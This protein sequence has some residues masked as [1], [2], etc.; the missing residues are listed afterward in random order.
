[1]SLLSSRSASS[2][3]VLSLAGVVACT[4]SKSGTTTSSASTTTTSTGGGWAYGGYGGYG[5]DGGY[6]DTGGYGGDGGEGGYGGGCFEDGDI[7]ASDLDCCGDDSYCI[8]GVCG[9]CGSDSQI[10][11]AA[12]GVPELCWPLTTD[13]STITDC[14]GAYKSC[15]S[16]SEYVDCST[17]TCDGEGSSTG[18]GDGG[19]TFNSDCDSDQICQYGSCVTPECQYNSDCDESDCY[20]CSDY[21]CVYC[22]EGPYGCYC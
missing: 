5:G 4:Q 19:C 12:N 13:C 15:T 16:P 20:R 21:Q 14:G 3:L 1:M 2:L 9:Q 22:G 10:C 6:G 8:E 11:E 7:C 18:S 17:D